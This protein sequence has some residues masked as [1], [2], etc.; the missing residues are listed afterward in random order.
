[1]IRAVAVFC[2]VIGFIAIL[3]TIAGAP[4]AGDVEAKETKVSGDCTVREVALD[5][6]Y[7]VSRK[8]SQQVCAN[9]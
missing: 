7:G 5:E 6:G 1:M 4:Q 9:Q 3:M 8:I 2:C